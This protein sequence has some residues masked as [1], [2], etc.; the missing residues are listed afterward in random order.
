MRASSDHHFTETE[1]KLVFLVWSLLGGSK[2]Q[3]ILKRNLAYFLA[4][5]LRLTSSEC[6][7]QK[8]DVFFDEAAINKPPTE[9]SS[10][11]P[12]E[13]ATLYQRENI[14]EISLGHFDHR[15]YW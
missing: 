15:T 7:L 12:S 10:S 11:T 3:T 9:S 4:I 2:Y 8:I 13:L 6:S 5:V 14:V 1:R